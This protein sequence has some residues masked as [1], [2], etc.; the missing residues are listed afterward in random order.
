MFRH[1][2]YFSTWVLVLSGENWKFAE[3]EPR[4][5]GRLWSALP[6]TRLDMTT[7]FRLNKLSKITTSCLG[8]VLRA[9][10]ETAAPSVAQFSGNYP[11]MQLPFRYP[12]STNNI[13]LIL[14]WC[15]LQQPHSFSR[16]SNS[17]VWHVL[18]KKNLGLCLF[19]KCDV[20]Q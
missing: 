8:I 5:L 16:A 20:I 12:P 13:Y 10:G 3:Q 19:G 14:C 9:G 4:S 17:F 15:F 1:L 6:S 7:I 2:N 18:Q 11:L